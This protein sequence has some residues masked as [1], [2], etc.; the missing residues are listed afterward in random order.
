MS[1]AIRYLLLDG[2]VLRGHALM[3]AVQQSKAATPLYADLGSDACTVGPWLWSGASLADTGSSVELPARLGVSELHSDSAPSELLT[4]FANIRHIET[5]DGQRYF[6]RYADMRALGAMRLTLD[7]AQW[8]FL[9]GP[10]HHWS[11]I[12]RHGQEHV[13][14]DGPPGITHRSVNGLRLTAKQLATLLDA[15]LPD[16]LCLAVEELDEP[17]LTPSTN[18]RQ[19]D[20]IE[21]AAQ[22]IRQE[23]I[24]AFALQR[25]IARQAVLLGNEA[26]ESPLFR[27]SINSAKKAGNAQAIDAWA[28][29]RPT[30]RIG[31]SQTSGTTP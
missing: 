2:A 9:A 25:A 23:G 4:H 19:F 22:L 27:D 20:C 17:L 29:E 8:A 7:D 28:P 6:L 31:G 24:E 21:A 11:F 13:L 30:A 1:E 16:Q 10:I 12:G 18:P 26:I 3:Q 5:H 15:G 14:I